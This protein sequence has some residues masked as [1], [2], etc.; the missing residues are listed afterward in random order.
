MNALLG[1]LIG[2]FTLGYALPSLQ[3]FAKGRAAGARLFHVIAR[4]PADMLQPDV[5]AEGT[6][7]KQVNG[8]LELRN[9]AFTY[10]ARPDTQVCT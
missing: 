7:L 10:P 9:V 2:A 5:D 4:K 6:I 3:H 8:Y 1:A